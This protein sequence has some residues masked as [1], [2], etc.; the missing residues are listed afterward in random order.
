MSKNTTNCFNETKLRVDA[1]N[2]SIKVELS[3]S[4]NAFKMTL[5]KPFLSGMNSFTNPKVSLY[6]PLKQ[7]M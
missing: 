7:N 5:Y 6:T 2:E 4:I 1:L 3:A